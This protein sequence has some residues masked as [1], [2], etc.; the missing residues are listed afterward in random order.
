MIAPPGTIEMPVLTQIQ[1]L[2]D[3][4]KWVIRG[5]AFRITLT[6]SRDGSKTLHDTVM[7]MINY[8]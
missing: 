1:T 4:N 3:V 2:I 8:A 5:V 6:S 7:R